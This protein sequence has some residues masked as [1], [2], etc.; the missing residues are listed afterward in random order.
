MLSRDNAQNELAQLKVYAS[1]EMNSFEETFKELDELLEEGM[2]AVHMHPGR[3][4][5]FLCSILRVC[6]KIILEEKL[7]HSCAAFK[8]RNARIFLVP[9]S[10]SFITEI[11]CPFLKIE[12]KVILQASGELSHSTKY[13]TLC[14][15]V[16]PI[17]CADSTCHI[18]QIG[19]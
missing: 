10:L 15:H 8:P 16:S 14:V 9:L 2:R 3:T 19:R 4:N 18:P 7:H 6:C 1:K 17:S 12:S 11:L 13:K 5:T